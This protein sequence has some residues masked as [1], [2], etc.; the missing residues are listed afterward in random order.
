MR[1]I[2]EPVDIAYQCSLI[3]AVYWA[4][5]SFYPIQDQ[6][7]NDQDYRYNVEY[8]DSHELSIPTE[9]GYKFTDSVTKDLNL[10]KCYYTEYVLKHGE[11]P[12]KPY[13]TSTMLDE[14]FK[15]DK[16]DED[17]YKSSLESITDYNNIEK[18]QSNFDN[19]LDDF[20]QVYVTETLLNLQH[21]NLTAYGRKLDKYSYKDI[22]VD[23]YPE[24]ETIDKRYWIKSDIDWDNCLLEKDN[25]AYIHILVDFDALV[26]CFPEPDGEGVNIRLH[27]GTYFYDSD[28]ISSKKTA[29]VGRPSFNWKQFT[30]E[31]IRKDRSN[32]LPRVQKTCVIEMQE[33]CLKN[34]KKV[35]SETSL[36][37]YIRPFYTTKSKSKNIS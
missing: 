10:P 13:F 32:K 4:A 28:Q 22:E 21:G 33:W 16:I 9:Y 2:L 27:N 11:L 35:P 20:L 25:D 24:H 23:S 18:Y 34:W 8:I 1:T 30:E 7:G 12:Y 14:M 19:A 37:E 15:K 36:K 26:D 5:F 29:K 17:M 6:T 31:M 3:E